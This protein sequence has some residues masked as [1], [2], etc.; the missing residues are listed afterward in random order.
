TEV[1]GPVSNHRHSNA[2]QIRQYEFTFRAVTHR[3]E[4]LWVDHLADEFVF[5]DV[6]AGL[7][8]ALEA[9]SSH[10]G[11]PDVIESLRSKCLLNP[12]SCFRNTGTGL[13][14]MHRDTDRASSHV[15]SLL[16]GNVRK[17][18]CIC[19]STNENRDFTL[20]DGLKALFCGLTST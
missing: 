12:I 17:T 3:N 6:H 19:G 20:K 8:L 11:H 16:H 2:T 9:I 14:S 10:F 5:V 1:P 4:R 7:M 15:E 13:A 18:Q